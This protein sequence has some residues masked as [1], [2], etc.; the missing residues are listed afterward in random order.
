MRSGRVSLVWPVLCISFGVS[1]EN[2]FN[3]IAVHPVDRLIE[4][5]Q[6]SLDHTHERSSIRPARF[7]INA[8][9]R[10]IDRLARGIDDT[11]PSSRIDI[12]ISSPPDDTEDSAPSDLASPPDPS[13]CPSTCPTSDSQIEENVTLPPDPPK[14]FIAPVLLTNVGTLF[15]LLA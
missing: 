15:D 4:V 12:Y 8:L 11:Q 9:R 3:P 10:E 1:S 14:I 5:H 2:R 13:R 7:V 6:A